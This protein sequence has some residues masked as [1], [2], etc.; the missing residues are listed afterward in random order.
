MKLTKNISRPKE[1]EAVLLFKRVKR[2]FDAL[3]AS[4]GGFIPMSDVPRFLQ[5]IPEGPGA[6][7][8][9]GAG[10]GAEGSGLNLFSSPEAIQAVQQR[11]DPDGLGLCLWRNVWSVLTEF[12]QQ[13]LRKEKNRGVDWEGCCRAAFNSADEAG[14]GFLQTDVGSWLF[15]L[16][17]TA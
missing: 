5:S 7:T 2:A 11:A 6:G 1:S 12:Q 14:V 17:E 15:F 8:G 3:D 4:E 9:T 16:V 10:A 13:Q